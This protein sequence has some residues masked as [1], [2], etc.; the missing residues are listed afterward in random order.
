M[1]PIEYLLAEHASIINISYKF[2]LPSEAPST[3]RSFGS[4]PRRVLCY[5]CLRA[6]VSSGED[7]DDGSVCPACLGN[8]KWGEDAA[9]Q[10]IVSRRRN[11]AILRMASYSSF[12]EDAVALFAPEQ[13]RDGIDLLGQP[14]PE[15]L[16]ATSYAT[17]S[18][19]LAAAPCNSFVW[20]SQ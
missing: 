1:E 18:A 19:A 6:T 13:P 3:T 11:P 12:G 2:A 4:C 20:N 7:L 16:G 10:V 15:T 14:L 8:P 5:S 17:P 9:R